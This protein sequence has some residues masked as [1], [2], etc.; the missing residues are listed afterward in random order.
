MSSL[1]PTTWRPPPPSINVEAETAARVCA[2]AAAAAAMVAGMAAVMLT[3]GGCH[4]H[5]QGAAAAP[6][7]AGR[8]CLHH[9]SRRGGMSERWR[10]LDGLKGKLVEELDGRRGGQRR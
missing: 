8:E 5:V 6:L 2:A 1:L 10:W 4:D 7:M 3:N 9:S